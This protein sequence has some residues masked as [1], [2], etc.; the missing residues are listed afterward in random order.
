MLVE[1]NGKITGAISGGCLE[2]DAL[3]KA[4]LVIKQKKSKLVT[5]NTL[6]EDDVKFGLQLGCNGMFIFCLSRLI[7]IN[8]TTQLHCWKNALISE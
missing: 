4:L 8:P 3:R 5:Y 2:G 6:Y 7:T 1:H